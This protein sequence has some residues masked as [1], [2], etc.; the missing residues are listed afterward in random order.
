MGILRKDVFLV[1]ARRPETDAIQR[2]FL[3]YAKRY[4]T[5]R[6]FINQ[7]AQ[8]SLFRQIRV[9]TDPQT[10]SGT[11]F[12]DNKKT[13]SEKREATCNKYSRFSLLVL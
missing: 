3:A 6:T 7:S 10:T 9:R 1:S 11:N 13:K 2:S 5:L 8:I 4:F 12:Q